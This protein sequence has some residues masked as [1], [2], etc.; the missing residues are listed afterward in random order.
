MAAVASGGAQEEKEQ[1]AGRYKAF[2]F[3]KNS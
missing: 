2:G 1:R 3:L